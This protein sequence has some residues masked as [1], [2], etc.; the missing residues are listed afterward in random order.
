MVEVTPFKG[1]R[2]EQ[3]GKFS[4][5]TYDIISDS[6]A[7]EFRKELECVIHCSLP[8]NGNNPFAAAM[9]SEFRTAGIIRQDDKPGFYI[10]ETGDDNYQQRGIIACVNINDYLEGGIHGHELTR[11][12]SLADRIDHLGRTRANIDPVWMLCRD[13]PLLSS[14]MDLMMLGRPNTSLKKFGY[15]HKLW[16]DSNPKNIEYIE[17]ILRN[18]SLYIADGHHRVGAA[19]EH[20]NK[21]GDIE[22]LMVFITLENESRIFPYNRLVNNVSREKLFD[23]LDSFNVE[24]ADF[25]KP[26]KKGEIVF[27]VDDSWFRAAPVRQEY[28]FDVEMLQYELLE[29]IGITDPRTDPNLSFVGGVDGDIRLQENQVYFSMFPITPQE[30]METAD[31]GNILPPKSTY[32]HPKPITGLVLKID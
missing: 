27:C 13:E 20:Y 28:K 7:R 30:L 32:F 17:E 5:K 26:E 21:Q 25:H 29:K 9:L 31:A 18:H 15:H 16:Q 3:P 10:Y 2:P 8:I 4:T 12:A 19:A 24:K 6:E 1:Y 22:H 14:Y 11:D 23:N